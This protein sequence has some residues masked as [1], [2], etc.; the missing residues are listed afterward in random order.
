MWT[1]LRNITMILTTN[2][3]DRQQIMNTSPLNELSSVSDYTQMLT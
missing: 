2:S 3:L 1:M